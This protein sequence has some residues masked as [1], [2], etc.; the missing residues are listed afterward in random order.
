[1]PSLVY[2]YWK[3]LEL[4]YNHEIVQ[5]PV[6]LI[7]FQTH[8]LEWTTDVERVTL[9]TDLKPLQLSGLC[10][11]TCILVKYTKVYIYYLALNVTNSLNTDKTLLKFK[12]CLVLRGTCRYKLLF[13]VR[14]MVK[15]EHSHNEAILPKFRYLIE[16]LPHLI[17]TLI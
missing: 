2:S 8:C 3:K 5:D 9:I 15:Y 12:N 13:T 1:M 14:I 11:D 7:S 6:S 10:E 17:C 4:D 16:F